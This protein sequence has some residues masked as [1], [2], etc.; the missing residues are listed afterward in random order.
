M[1]QQ[2]TKP[3]TLGF[4]MAD[5][6]IALLAWVYEKLRD[7][8]DEYPWTDDEILTWV[9]IYQFST[10]GP[11]A[12]MRIYYEA[13]HAS[14]EQFIKSMQ[15]VPRVPLGISY[16]PKDL[17]PLPKS[18]VRTLGPIVF[19][20]D[21]DRGGHFAAY[22]CPDQFVGDLKVMFSKGG[23]GHQAVKEFL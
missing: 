12:S 8:T 19:E 13:S 23:G 10:A 21:H 16:Y 11:A 17:L 20:I 2:S 5:S 14:R 9:S 4:A 15:Y 18:C 3:S 22:E 1:V 7:W 6:P